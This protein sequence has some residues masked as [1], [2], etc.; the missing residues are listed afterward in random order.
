FVDES[1]LT[2]ESLPV[3]RSSRMQ[4]LAG[5]INRD[6]IGNVRVIRTGAGTSLAEVGRLLERAKADRPP[7]AQ[8][9]DR[10]ASYFVVGVL[11]L[12]ALT[13]A[14]W[15]QIDPSRAFEVVLATLVVTCPCALALATPT[16]LA[17]A[18]STL[19]SNGFLL[20]RSRLLEVLG[21][22]AVL[23]FDKTGTLTEGRPTVQRTECYRDDWS[24]S[25]CLA[26]AAAIETASTHV[27]AR[28]FAAHERPGEFTIGEIDIAAGQGGGGGRGGRRAARRG[29]RG[30]GGGRGGARGRGGAGGAREGA[31]GA[32]GGEGGG[33]GGG[34][35]EGGGG[36]GRG[37]IS[38]TSPR[39]IE[40]G[41]N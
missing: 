12:V 2:G 39:A 27:L 11:I 1:M 33:G 15:S 22:G 5:S 14:V 41:G 34:G 24:A 18:A 4:V 28:A 35:G 23:V 37:L 36:G 7:V 40:G 19:A 13:G 9:A 20:V 3:R 32:A 8:L 21:H 38:R 10:V 30:G 16:A 25:R 17:A 26:L 29:A 31:G 6:G